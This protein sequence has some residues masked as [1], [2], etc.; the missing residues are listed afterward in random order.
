MEE[1]SLCN[2]D[3]DPYSKPQ[4]L[5]SP[6]PTKASHTT[7][8]T[9]KDLCGRGRKTEEHM[10]RKS[11]VRLCL[12]ESTEKLQPGSLPNMAAK[13]QADGG[14]PKDRLT[15]EGKSP[16]GLNPP[17]RTTDNQ[18]VLTA[19]EIS[20]PQGRTHQLVIQEHGENLNI[21]ESLHRLS[22][23]HLCRSGCSGA[24]WFL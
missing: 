17:Q 24:L 19:E 6:A 9:P 13:S 4:H 7:T 11:A 18:G 16:E 15:W 20:L 2:R 21:Q 23:K 1:T 12:L 10:S 22:T 3:S 8:P 5:Q 14:T